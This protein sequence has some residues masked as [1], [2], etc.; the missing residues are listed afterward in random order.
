MVPYPTYWA[1]FNQFQTSD[2]TTS[3]IS[4]AT[5]P[6]AWP[7]IFTN[8]GAIITPSDFYALDGPPPITSITTIRFIYLILV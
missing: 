7:S 8:P 6:T 4:V 2:F 1:N 3:F 5:N